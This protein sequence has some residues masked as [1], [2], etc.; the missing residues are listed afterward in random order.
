VRST[1]IITAVAS[2]FFVGLA[3]YMLAIDQLFAAC[4]FLILPALPWLL[5]NSSS[6]SKG[7]WNGGQW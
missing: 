3:L 5:G 2:S 7:K 1:I 6:A 4:V